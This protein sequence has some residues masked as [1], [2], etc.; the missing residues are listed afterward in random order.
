M[1]TNLDGPSLKDSKNNI[2]IWA[3]SAA[4]KYK[5][6]AN[7]VSTETSFFRGDKSIEAL[8]IILPKID[9]KPNILLVGCGL[10][11]DPLMCC[12]EPFRIGAHLEAKGVDYS[13]T[14]VD[15]DRYV[16]DDIKNRTKL[17]VYPKND[18]IRVSLA[19]RWNKYLSDTKQSGYETTT[20]ENGMNF[21]Q[22]YM[23]VDSVVSYDRYLER[24]VLVAN[25]SPLFRTKLKDGGVKLIN[26]DIATADLKSS[27]PFDYIDLQNVLYLM[28]KSGQ[29]LAVANVTR[30]LK[31]GGYLLICDIV[32]EKS[33]IFKRLGGWLD[34]KKIKELGLQSVEGNSLGSKEKYS[35][36]ELFRKI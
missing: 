33:P 26:D 9:H 17:F 20:L 7:D 15:V 5:N 3:V 31:S 12:Y 11:A 14:L 32:R 19:S 16:I 10:D 6:S 28:S 25:V 23:S 8:G 36:T 21:A 18:Q 24:G 27:G 4:E 2:P 29:Q 30:S 22:E 35:Q 34:S 13:M 1:E